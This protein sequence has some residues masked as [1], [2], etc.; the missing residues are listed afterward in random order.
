M[1]K[2]L[3]IDFIIKRQ[4]AKACYRDDLMMTYK[5]VA[6]EIGV[7]VE[8]IRHHVRSGNISPAC[9]QKLENGSN[10]EVYLFAKKDVMI[11]KAN[12]RPYQYR[13]RKGRKK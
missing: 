8:S 1:D 6:D 10:F 12:K 13:N 5:Q 2:I 7:S 3:L 11:F 9:R 4:L